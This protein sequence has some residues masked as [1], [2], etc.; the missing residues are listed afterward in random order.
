LSSSVRVRGGYARIAAI[1]ATLLLVP[2]AA[3]ADEPLKLTITVSAGKHDRQNVP[4]RVPIAVPEGIGPAVKLVDPAGKELPAQIGPPALLASATK[5][6]GKVAREL[7]FTLEKL[8]AGQAVELTATIMA[9]KP[10]RPRGSFHWRLYHH[11][12]VDLSATLMSDRGMMLK[13]ECL[14]FDD[15]T[16]EARHETYKVF[17]HVYSPDGKTLLTKGAGGLYPHHR[18]LFYGFNKISYGDGKKADTWHCTGDAHQSHEK[19]L[20]LMSGILVGRHRV[21]IDWHGEKKEVFAREQRELASYHLGSANQGVII[22]FASRL[23]AAAGPVKLAGDPQHAGFQFRAAQEVAEKTKSQT[24]Y[25]RPDGVGKPGQTRNWPGD[26]DQVNLPWKAMSFVV[27]GQRYTVAYL[28]HPANPKESRWSERD[29]GRFGCY[30][31]Y[32]LTS[33]KP[34]EVRYRL[35][36][37]PGEMTIAEVARLSADFAEPV[38]VSVK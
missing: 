17:H 16:P 29:Y 13:Y 14:P 35:W 18:G 34:L 6:A 23:T 38:E 21:A 26:K 20:G 11:E 15:S 33:E 2:L 10:N 1:C 9:G 22:D 32:E 30:F 36:I 24:Y 31:E 19:D 8:P 25:V 27:G 7:H 5:S 37:Q 12:K 28:D 3:L 4:V